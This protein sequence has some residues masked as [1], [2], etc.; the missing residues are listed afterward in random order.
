VNSRDEA[1]WGQAL[2]AR[3]ERRIRFNER[4]A[5]VVV[6]LSLLTIVGCALWRVFG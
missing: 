4:L 3:L 6:L 1:V 2:I 5:N